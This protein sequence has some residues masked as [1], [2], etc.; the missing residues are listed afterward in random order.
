LQQAQPF[1]NKISTKRLLFAGYGEK[2][3]RRVLIPAQA[4]LPQGGNL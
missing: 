2:I 3:T 4:V 1:F